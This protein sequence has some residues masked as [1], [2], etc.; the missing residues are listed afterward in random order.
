VPKLCPTP[1]HSGTIQSTPAHAA[2]AGR[3]VS[4]ANEIQDSMCAAMQ[5]INMV[6]CWYRD[7]LPPEELHDPE[8][9]SAGR[10]CRAGSS[11]RGDTY[12]RRLI[13]MLVGGWEHPSAVPTLIVPSEVAMVFGRAL[14]GRPSCILPLAVWLLLAVVAFP[15]G[16]PAAASPGVLPMMTAWRADEGEPDRDDIRS[17]LL[18]EVPLTSVVVHRAP[19]VLGAS[20]CAREHI[21][22]DRSIVAVWNPRAPP[23]KSGC[24]HSAQ[25]RFALAVILKGPPNALYLPTRSVM[26]SVRRREHHLPH[27]IATR[28]GVSPGRAPP[29]L[30]EGLE[31]SALWYWR[32]NGVVTRVLAIA[33][34]AARQKAWASAKASER[35]ES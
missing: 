17:S 32:G 28:T 1:A 26:F 11:F 19:W 24:Q 3:P 18:H 35:A 30:V 12:D 14:P 15:G 4:V 9:S 6:P 23:S 25:H 34:L 33:V 29:A 16:S 13:D 8:M 2:V 20:A 5:V 21:L 10:G 7:F 31:G 22:V 27:A